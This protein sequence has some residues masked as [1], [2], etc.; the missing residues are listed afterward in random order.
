MLNRPTQH[1]FMENHILIKPKLNRRVIN[2]RKLLKSKWTAI[3]PSNK[4]KHFI[5]T[6][7]IL[8]DLPEMPIE[9]IELEAI[10][11]KRKQIIN[12]ETIIDKNTWAQGWF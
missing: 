2:P 6:K 4:E 8:P 3:T 7:I 1:S 9:F 12:L 5:V 11:S 10:H